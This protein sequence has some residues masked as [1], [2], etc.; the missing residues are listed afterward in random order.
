ME[1]KGLCNTCASGRECVLTQKFPVWQCEEFDNSVVVIKE[2]NLPVTVAE[3]GKTEK[4]IFVCYEELAEK[5]GKSMKDISMGAIGVY[6]FAQKLK[7]GL[8]Q[9]M[10]G[11]RCFSV[12]VITR[13]DLMSLTEE[14]A[15]VTGIPY[16]M[17][18]YREEAMEILNS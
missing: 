5:Y 18:A 16:L 17:D 15:K 11:A 7:V 10:A 2:K 8:Q 9:L 12:P 14:C 3:F 4:E 6:S 13:R 1:N